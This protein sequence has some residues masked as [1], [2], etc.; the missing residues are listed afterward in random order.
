VINYKVA[1]VVISGSAN[2]RVSLHFW[3]GYGAVKNYRDELNL[4]PDKVVD[5]INILSPNF[6][7][8]LN[9]NGSFG[10]RDP[11][12]VY[13]AQNITAL[14]QNKGAQVIPMVNGSGAQVDKILTTA[15]Y[16]KN[17]VN[18]AVKLINQT[19]ADGIVVNLEILAT[20]SRSGLTS[21]MK[22]L[23]TAL[24]P[25]GKLVIISVMPKTS[26]TAEPWLKAFDYASISPYADYV[27]V[28][29]YDKHYSTSAP[30]P[31]SP[32]DW[33]RSVLQY[34]VQK[35]PR[36]KILLGIPYYGRAWTGNE[37]DGYTSFSLSWNKAV[38][39]IAIPEGISISR[40]TTATDPVGVPTF[41]YTDAEGKER[42]VYFD[43]A[44]S[45][46]EKLKLLDQFQIGGVAPWSMLWANEG[47]ADVIYP[48]I[49][50]TLK[51]E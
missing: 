4:V 49:K 34:T 18:S 5:Y 14:G 10:Y 6:A 46:N 11:L 31:I 41:K 40:E 17:F 44:Q 30:G 23:Y 20:D 48:L 3:D 43:D 19:N 26:D 25:M 16:R 12:T 8:S 32:L 37:T 35:I 29:T 51:A 36:E 13:D 7:G 42:T 21:L 2:S 9:D 27:Q 33:M 50:Q 28:M 38:N 22:E 39:E 15:E 24:H 1:G 47:S 45:W